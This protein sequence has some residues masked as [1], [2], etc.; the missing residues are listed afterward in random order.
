MEIGQLEAFER[1]AQ[2]GSFSAAAEE[3]NLSQPAVS[4]RITTL[5]ALVGGALFERTGTGLALTDLGAVFL[6]YATQCLSALDQGKEMIRR[7]QKGLHGDV[8]FGSLDVPAM[9][10]LPD[11]IRRFR[12]A[13][14]SVDLSV[15]VRNA[16]ALL[17][18]LHTGALDAALIGTRV[19]DKRLEVL[20]RFIEPISAIASAHHPLAQYAAEQGKITIADLTQHTIFR[21]MFNRDITSVVDQLVEQARDASGGAVV[22]INGLLA[23]DLV[24]EGQGVAFL[25]ENTVKR[26]LEDGSLVRLE[27]EDLPDF[28]NE[29]LIVKDIQRQLPAPTQAFIDMICHQWRDIRV[30]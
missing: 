17:I 25:A 28:R 13:F 10:F 6:P 16:P 29:L 22:Q 12:E 8:R 18:P 26:Q 5:E 14:P 19:L 2:L 9:Y 30:T 4:K 1:A 20:A 3:L 21:V 15:V 7:F 27:I 24:A 23:I 11:P